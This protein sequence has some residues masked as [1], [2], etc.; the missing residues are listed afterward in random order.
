MVHII[1]RIHKKR[2]IAR[3]R[4]TSSAVRSA[5]FRSSS[6]PSGLSGSAIAWCTS[7]V[8]SCSNP[9]RDMRYKSHV[10]T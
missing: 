8:N 4:R 2:I 3:Q 6:L 10:F 5:A 9:A 7:E 1:H